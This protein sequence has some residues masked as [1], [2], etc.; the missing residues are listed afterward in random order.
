MNYFSLLRVCRGWILVG[1]GLISLCVAAELRAAVTIQTADGR[2]LRGEIDERTTDET[3]WIRQEE[4]AIV[5]ATS[6][7]WSAVAGAAIDGEAIDTAALFAQWPQLQS[8]GPARKLSET[9]ELVASG[10]QRRLPLQIARRIVAIEIEA[11]LIN[12]DRYVEPDG[13]SLRIAAIDVDGRPVPVRGSITAR[14][15]GERDEL[16]TGRVRFEELQRWSQSV[17]LEDFEQGVANYPLRFRTV[18]P[19]F[20]WELI[21]VALLNVRLGVVGQGNYEA[22]IPVELRQFNPFRDQL[23]QFER[24]RFLPNE[25]TG[26]VRRRGVARPGSGLQDWSR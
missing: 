13:L 10:E 12:M 5:L 15:V 1:G 17:C 7:D 11:F 2:E 9:M 4:E 8:V 26:R 14:L 24:S 18:R 3:L 25:L 19:E 21:P 23:Q 16:R 20:D 22:S 6:V